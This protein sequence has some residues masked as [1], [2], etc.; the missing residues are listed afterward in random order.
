MSGG[1]G[2]SP[3]AVVVNVVEVVALVAAL[4]FVVMLFANEPDDAGVAGGDAAEAGEVDGAAIYGDNCASCHGGDGQ[5]GIGP[6]LAGGAVVDAFPDQA[7][8]IEV[9]TNGRGNMPDF[10]NDLTPEQ[11]E[12]VVV[13]TREEL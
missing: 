5:G 9:V 7:D 8:Q 10:G 4:A 6:A 1:A 2:K 11:I 13:Y 3:F 12:A